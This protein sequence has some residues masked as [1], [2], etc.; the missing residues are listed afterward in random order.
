LNWATPAFLINFSRPNIWGSIVKKISLL[1]LALAL[2]AFTGTAQ[3]ATID[4]AFAS[5][6]SIS[7]FSGPAGLPPLYGGLVFSASNPNV[8]L[9]GG[10][11]NGGA[12]AI[13]SVTVTRDAG[14]HVNGTVGTP[15]LYSTA[16]NIDGGLAYSPTGVLF[17][18]G[19]PNNTIGQITSGAAPARIDSA[20][21]SL[22]SL[23]SLNFVPTG[24][25]NAGAL[26]VASYNNGSYGVLSLSSDGSGTYNLGALTS[27]VGNIPGGPEGFVYIKAGNDGFSANS[28]LI[29]QYGTG[30][31]TAYEVDAQGLPILATGRLFIS[32]LSGAEGSTIDPLTGDFL[33]STF[34][35]GNQIAV[36]QGFD[37]PVTAVPE[38][39]TW[40]MLILGFAGVGFMAYRRRNQAA[41]PTLT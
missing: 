20:P 40:A 2:P 29:A 18:T 36:V 28:M 25:S 6:Y 15:T 33:F 19:Y 13:Y 11:A 22:S 38:P 35:G 12:G 24:F 10:A 21:S 7:T 23:G 27:G 16:P 34:G 30:T 37:V 31:V 9:I 32:G 5:D 39:S 8:L 17:F 26:V 41:V 3:S 1:A 14:G 4:A